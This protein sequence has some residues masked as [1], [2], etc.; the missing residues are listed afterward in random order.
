[1]KLELVK[2]AVANIKLAPA[3]LATNTPAPARGTPAVQV[4]LATANTPPAPAPLATD[5]RT[6][7]VKY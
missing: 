2:I 6:A 1:M 4:L 5:G 3:I 7:L